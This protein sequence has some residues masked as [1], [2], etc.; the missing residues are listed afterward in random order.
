[1]RVPELGQIV[2]IKDEKL[3]RRHWKLGKIMNVKVSDRD[4]KIREVTVQCLSKR[5]Q[6]SE[7]TS[8]PLPSTFLRKS[9]CHL[10]PLEVEPEYYSTDPMVEAS[11]SKQKTS[12]KKVTFA[13]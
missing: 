8:G 7:I 4:G 13:I 10:V 1:M 9:P 11:I 3:P 5:A 6:N 2:L 12:A